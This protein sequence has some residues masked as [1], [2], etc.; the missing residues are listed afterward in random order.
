[1]HTEMDALQHNHTWDI[2]SFPSGVKHV[3][4]RWVY[5]LKFLADGTIDRRKA[6]LAAKGFTQVL[7]RDFG[8]TFATVAKLTTVCLIISV[9]ASYSWLLHQLD[10]K[11]AFHHSDLDET[12]Y[13]YAPIGFRGEG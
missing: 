10:V 2:V 1:M 9:T 3:S 6:R 8:T 11:N 4:C 13:M 12:I 5:A 7:G